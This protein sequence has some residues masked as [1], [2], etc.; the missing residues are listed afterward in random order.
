MEANPTTDYA[1]ASLAT[2]SPSKI[3]QSRPREKVEE[4]QT[5]EIELPT[6][7][8][9]VV[10]AYIE[11]L[12]AKSL[13]VDRTIEGRTDFHLLARLYCFG[14]KVLDDAFCNAVMANMVAGMDSRDVMGEFSYPTVEAIRIVYEG[15]P[16]GSPMRRFVIEMYAQRMSKDWASV[17]GAPVEFMVE[18]VGEM[19]RV[20]SAPGPHGPVGRRVGKWLKEKK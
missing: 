9:D 6:D 14:E 3:L 8:D 1:S 13:T 10:A 2:S 16:A 4:G 11:Y 19:C 15:T 12:Y 7:H 18:L 5:R 20:R 17:E